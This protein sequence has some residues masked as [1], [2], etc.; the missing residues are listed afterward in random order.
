LNSISDLEKILLITL[1]FFSANVFSQSE[2]A[3][4]A[5]SSISEGKNSIQS[6]FYY[7]TPEI[8]IKAKSVSKKGYSLFSFNSAVL[9][10]KRKLLL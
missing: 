8:P 10:K 5:F 7:T 1:F 3:V 9:I 4:F 6:S 2:W